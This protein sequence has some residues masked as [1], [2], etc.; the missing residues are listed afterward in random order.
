MLTVRLLNYSFVVTFYSISENDNAVIESRTAPHNF[1]YWEFQGDTV[2]LFKSF[3][4]V[5]KFQTIY[6]SADETN[7]LSVYL[8]YRLAGLC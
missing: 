3:G 1:L 7:L 2:S 6:R 8:H 4:G 5:G